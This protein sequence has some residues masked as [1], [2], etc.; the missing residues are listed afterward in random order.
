MLRHVSHFSLNL[1]RSQ[2]WLS[3]PQTRKHPVQNS[4]YGVCSLE[5]LST[6]IDI[7]IVDELDW[8]SAVYFGLTSKANY[9][10]L[11]GARKRLMKSVRKPSETRTRNGFCLYPMS[12]CNSLAERLWE[13]RGG[14]CLWCGYTSNDIEHWCHALYSFDCEW[15]MRVAE[16]NK[17]LRKPDD[18]SDEWKRRDLRARTRNEYWFTLYDSTLKGDLRLLRARQKYRTAC[19]ACGLAP[20]RRLTDPEQVLENKEEPNFKTRI[21]RWLLRHERTGDVVGLLY[22]T[23][24][25]SGNERYEGY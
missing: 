14:R 12:G 15:C 6:E 16:G 19:E 25:Y 24:F 4:A 20:S 23:W 3:L 5:S 22:P 2:C 7:R 8:V 17:S 13:W 18:L 11:L 1:Q 9:N 21:R 10:I